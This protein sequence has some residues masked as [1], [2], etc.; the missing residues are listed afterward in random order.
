MHQFFSC[1]HDPQSINYPRLIRI[2]NRAP[3]SMPE[4]GTHFAVLQPGRRQSVIVELGDQLQDEGFMRVRVRASRTEG[5]DQRVPS[6]QLAFGF[7]ATDQ[8]GSNKQ[9]GQD[10]QVSAVYGQPEI[11][12]WY[13]PLSEI[14]HRNTYRGE[15]KLGDQPN[16]SEFISF[17]NTS[18]GKAT[19]GAESSAGATGNFSQLLS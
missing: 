6:M 1:D 15:M 16:P 9:L 4:T 8:G 11:Y 2:S 10:V 12:E 7:R 3:I 13:V 18:I 17:R 5:A 19:E 14:E